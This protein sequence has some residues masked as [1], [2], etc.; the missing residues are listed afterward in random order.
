[1]GGAGQVV[2]DTVGG[3]AGDGPVTDAVD[4]VT[5]TVDDT[6]GAVTDAVDDT[7]GGLTGALGGG[8]GG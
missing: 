7:V 6:V 5:D 8:H 2:D 1:M 3:V 4:N